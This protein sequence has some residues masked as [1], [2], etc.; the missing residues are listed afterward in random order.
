MLGDLVGEFAPR[1]AKFL[2]GIALFAGGFATMASS[3][4]VDLRGILKAAW[5]RLRRGTV[6]RSR[7]VSPHSMARECHEPFSPAH[8]HRNNEESED[9]GEPVAGQEPANFPSSRSIAERFAPYA[10]RSPGPPDME[11]PLPGTEAR[12]VEICARGQQL[13]DALADYGVKGEI[14]DIRP[15]PVV[16]L[17]ELEPA[18]GTKSSRVIGLADDIARSM[19]ALSARIAVV[20]GRNAMGIELPNTAR[21]KV[22][23][24]DLIEDESFRA[25]EGSLPLALGKGIGGEPIVADLA[26][27]PHLLVAGTTGSGKSVGVN[28]MILSLLYRHAPEDVPAAADRSED[29]GA[30]R[31][32]LH[33]ASTDAGGD[34]C[35]EGCRG[36]FLGGRRDGRAL[37][38]DG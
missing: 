8:R 16:T 2:V 26:R 21:E 25:A 37:Q 35:A 11:A 36:S 33:S 10:D 23:L 32:Q 9:K 20:P 17:F 3:I 27:M 31:L 4:G 7:A 5:V 19:S 22:V 38:A 28:A 1:P 14:R 29:A 6:A 12:H 34:R 13:I 18:R 30:R 24:R 15:G